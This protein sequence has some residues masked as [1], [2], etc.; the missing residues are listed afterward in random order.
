M[1][2][3]ITSE[4]DDIIICKEGLNQLHVLIDIIRRIG[5]SPEAYI[6]HFMERILMMKVSEIFIGIVYNWFA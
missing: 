6:S 4:L 2:E 1:R 3:S 5:G